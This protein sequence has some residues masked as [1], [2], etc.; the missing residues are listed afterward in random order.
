VKALTLRWIENFGLSVWCYIMT[1]LLPAKS[2]IW[3]EFQIWKG[4]VLSEETISQY[5]VSPYYAEIWR[6]DALNG[7]HGV[8]VFYTVVAVKNLNFILFS[9]LSS[10]FSLLSSLFSLLSSLFSLLSSLSCP[11][12]PLMIVS[13]CQAACDFA[14]HIVIP[15]INFSS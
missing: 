5:L 10:L 1:F 14:T 13:V 9:L 3:I 4:L 2:K 15:H 12:L 11:S 7:V 8:S 6:S